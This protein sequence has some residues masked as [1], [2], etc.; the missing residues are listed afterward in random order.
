MKRANKKFLAVALALAMVCARSATAMAAEAEK[1][2]L[3]DG[4]PGNDPD[5]ESAYV[6]GGYSE[7]AEFEVTLIVEAGDQFDAEYF[8]P[9]PDTAFTAAIAVVATERDG[10]AGISVQ[11]V[12]LSANAT[13]DCPV[14]FETKTVDMH[15]TFAG[16]VTY[17]G[18]DRTTGNFGVDGWV[19]RVN[20]MFPVEAVSGG[21]IG[22]LIGDTPVNDD[23][24]VYFYYDL[25]SGLN[26][27]HPDV[28]AKF[29]RGEVTDV[30]G[31]N[32]TVQLQNCSIYIDAGLDPD[33]YVYAYSDVFANLNATLIDS[34]GKEFE[35]TS[36]G[37]GTVTF[38]GN[39]A[40]GE[41]I[42]KTDKVL[43]S[44]PDYD[45]LDGCLM[46]YTGAYCKVTIQ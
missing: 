32:V 15:E 44:L 33:M 24:I 41:A 22:T 14:R 13:P 26:N 2:L 27:D 16:T 42:L 23:D 38:I 28:A 1:P 5:T 39:I 10:I 20:D 35:A 17:N 7:D 3:G 25:P 11:D 31:D 21:Y 43:R 45:M 30:D 29:V 12:L 40:A 37:N 36:D 18:L 19:F 9:T 46:E 34:D 4:L 8:E 6:V